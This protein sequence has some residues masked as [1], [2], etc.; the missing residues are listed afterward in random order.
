[1]KHFDLS[2]LLKID[3]EYNK[4]AI[5]LTK[6]WNCDWS[7][8]VHESYREYIK[9]VNGI[10]EDVHTIRSKSET[11]QKEIDQLNVQDLCKKSDALCLEAKSV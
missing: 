5:D 7:D 1:M 4:L 3:R 11:M 9:T 2:S 6:S 8:A 10:A